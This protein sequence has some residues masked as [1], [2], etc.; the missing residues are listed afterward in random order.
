MLF[1]SVRL[2][3]VSLAAEPS[4]ARPRGSIPWLPRRP[5]YPLE[6][7]AVG[8]FGDFG[9]DDVAGLTLLGARVNIQGH[10]GQTQDGHLTVGGAVAE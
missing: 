5:A 4:T 7:L 3:G 2:V 10:Q 6:L 9:G 8:E 1:I